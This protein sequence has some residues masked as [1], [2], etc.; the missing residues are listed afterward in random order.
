VGVRVLECGVANDRESSERY[1]RERKEANEQAER[2]R[3]EERMSADLRRKE[4]RERHHDQERR[5]R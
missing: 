2:E 3:K 5:D 4:A 1:E